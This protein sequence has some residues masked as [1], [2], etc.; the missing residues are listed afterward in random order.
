MR[1]ADWPAGHR[2]VGLLTA[3]YR[4]LRPACGPITRSRVVSEYLTIG[5]VTNL[6]SVFLCFYVPMSLCFYVSMFFTGV[7]NHCFKSTIVI[8]LPQPIILSNHVMIHSSGPQ[9]PQ[10]PQHPFAPSSSCPSNP[11]TASRSP[12]QCPDHRPGAGPHAPQHCGTT[13][14]P[15]TA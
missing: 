3:A 15:Q 4:C 7:V 11:E 14:H 2:A 6:S 8:M 9:H 12:Q 13:Y 5:R 1:A 10:H